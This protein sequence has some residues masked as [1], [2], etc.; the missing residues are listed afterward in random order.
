M[1]CTA[2]QRML[3]ELR[4]EFTHDVDCLV[5]CA[6]I[7]VA[8]LGKLT[9]GLKVDRDALFVANRA[10]LGVADGRERVGSDRQTGNAEGGQALDVGVV[11]CHLA[12]LVGVLVM[13]KVDDIDRVGVQLGCISQYL[14]VVCTHL[15]IVQ[16]FVGNRLDARDNQFALLL[17][18][19]A[20]DGIQQALRHVAACAEELHL[21]TDLHGRYAA[22]DGIVVAVNGTHDVVVFVLDGVGRNAHL[23]AVGFEALRQ[24]LAP[25]HGQVGF[26]R[27]VQVSQ[28]MQVAERVLGDQG[29][30]VNAHAADGLGHP[31]RVAAKQLVVLGRAQVTHQT[32]LDD[33]LVDELLCTG[34]VQNA[35]VQI[36]L[37][38]DVQEGR[39]TA[40]RGRRAVVLL[41]TG[42]IC[43]VQKLHRLVRVLCRLGQVDPVACRH[44]LDLTQ[45]ADLLGN[46]LAQADAL[47]I[48]WAVNIPEIV[49]FLLDQ[50]VNSIERHAAV[51]ADDTAAAVGIG[52]AG[53]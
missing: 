32:Q 46:F 51:V 19:T 27:R 40:E 45:C 47:L 13:H 49:L 26:G 43:H 29:L 1:L 39:R 36:A 28:R 3:F 34:F 38:V 30:T 53:Q 31:S 20:V 48:H 2:V 23:G 12:G 7:V 17:V 21:L 52:Q 42:Q 5:V 35:R 50:A 25:E 8:I 10:Y 22:G 44:G 14:V 9:H 16:N 41:D 15:V 4:R 6:V 18:H 24:V 33:E 11:Q 37:D